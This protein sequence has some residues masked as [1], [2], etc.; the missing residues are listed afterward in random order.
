MNYPRAARLHTLPRSVGEEYLGSII[1]VFSE[2][3]KNML[4]NFCI[5]F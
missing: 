3:P 5:F 2:Y 4:C 1:F